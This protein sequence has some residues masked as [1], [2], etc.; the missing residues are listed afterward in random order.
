MTSADMTTT[1][2]PIDPASGEGVVD[3]GAQ[4][5]LIPD[6]NYQ[7]VFL[8][9]ETSNVFKAAKVFLHFRVVDIGPA[10]EQTLFRAYGAKML[11]GRTGR[12]GRFRLSPRSDLLAMLCRISGA[13]ARPDRV[14]PAILKGLLLEIR[15]RTVNTDYKQRPLPEFLHYSVV[16]DVVG[17]LG[18]YGRTN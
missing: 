18:G 7:A 10:Y 3:Y 12:G 16:D 9:H 13:K 6:G 11:E 14:S 2:Y 1:L 17:V 8:H 4:G 5:V 15:T